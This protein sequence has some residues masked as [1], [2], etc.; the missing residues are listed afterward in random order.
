MSNKDVKQILRRAER[1]GARLVQRKSGPIEV[2][3]PKGVELVHVSPSAG[4]HLGMLK[5]KLRAIG[6]KLD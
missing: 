4:M 5:R 1:E 6:L 2:H 3:G